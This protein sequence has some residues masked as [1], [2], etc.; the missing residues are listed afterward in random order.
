MQGD[1]PS[2]RFASTSPAS[3]GGK[4]SVDVGQS[5]DDGPWTGFQK[6]GVLLAAL[7]ILL[8]G[9][10]GQLIGYAIPVI[11]QEWGVSREAFAPVVAAGLIGMGIGSVIAGY[12]SDRLGRRVAIIGSVLLFGVATSAIGFSEN[13]A[14]IALLRFVAG[15]G[16]GGALPT[17]TTMSAELT[18]ARRRTLAITGTIVCVPLGGMLAGVYAGNILPEFGWRVLFWAGGALP[19]LLSLVLIAFLPESPRFLVRR[20]SRWRELKSLLARMSRPVDESAVFTD[21]AEQRLERRE[22]FL[23]LFQADRIRDTVA[24]WVAFFLS[25]L[26]VYTA[27]SW[28]PTMLTSEGLNVGIGAAGLAAY[29][30]GGVIGALACAVAI[31]RFGSRWPIAVAC[32]GGALS[33]FFLQG[34]SIADT[35]LLILGLGIHGLFVNGAQSTMF[36]LCAYVYPTNVRATGTASAM[37]FGRLGAILSAFAGAAVISAGG[38]DAYFG[39][40]ALA[41]TGVLIALMAVKNHVPAFGSGIANTGGAEIPRMKAIR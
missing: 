2:A 8:D 17:C 4:S 40:L 6:R 36:V 11:I 38:A 9:F 7:A 37:G 16:I 14:T 20:P 10:D 19:A 25:L 32:G 13:L 28:L 21:A 1:P 33:A 27:F 23:A 22:G 5:I 35:N 12:I 41:M 24:L 39:M 26:S 34:A 30:L 29:N 31:T 15:L 18:P 3:G